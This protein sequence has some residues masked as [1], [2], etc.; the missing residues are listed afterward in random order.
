MTEDTT[1]ENGAG[2]A[3][4]QVVP[5]AKTFVDAL[6]AARAARSQA[7]I[8]ARDLES[9]SAR[10][11]K[12]TEA[13]QAYGAAKVAA[14]VKLAES[15]HSL[16]AWIGANIN[17]DDFLEE[18]EEVL[19]ELTTATTL[20]DLDELADANSWCSEWGYQ[21]DRAEAAG[22]FTSLRTA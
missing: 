13:D 9:Y 6:T 18:V 4:A 17:P 14:W 19:R 3:E 20:D 15:E 22:A 2:T 16:V 10:V 12:R 1:T 11:N 8:E 7:L 21:R 5:D